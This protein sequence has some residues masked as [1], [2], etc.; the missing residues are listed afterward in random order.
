M[1]EIF[2]ITIEWFLKIFGLFWMFGSLFLFVVINRRN[3]QVDHFI[4]S[5]ES[6]LESINNSMSVHEE[7]TITEN[8]PDEYILEKSDQVTQVFLKIGTLFT[9][10]SGLGLVLAKHW[11]ILPLCTLCMTQMIYFGIKKSLELQ[12]LNKKYV[13]Y[14]QVQKSTKN[15]FRTTIIVTALSLIMIWYQKFS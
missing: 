15:A 14:L 5:L 3:A 7:I 4:D 6:E 13:E 2:L 10:I 1:L 8:D 11:V 12:I 9:S